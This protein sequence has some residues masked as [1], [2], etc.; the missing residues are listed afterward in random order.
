MATEPLVSAVIPTYN[1]SKLLPDAIESALNQSY[2]NIEIIVVDDGST[3]DTSKVCERYG[4]NIRYIRRAN[5][6]T[7]AARNSGLQLA[8]GDFV[9]LLDHDD[10]WLPT[11]IKSQVQ[12]MLQDEAIGLVH[13][14]GRVIDLE[15]GITTSEYVAVAETDYHQILSWCSVGCASAMIRRSVLDQLGGFDEDLHGVDDWDLWIRI[16]WEFRIVGIPDVQ[17]IIREHGG[18][19]G[20]RYRRMYPIVRRCIDKNRPKHDGCELC[21]LAIQSARRRLKQDY[22]VKAGLHSRQ[23]AKSGRMLDAFRAKLDSYKVHPLGLFYFLR[24]LRR[25]RTS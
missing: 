7:P 5:G 22:F 12:A 11:K 18:N 10:C 20:K 8:K 1:C 16:G 14:G 9:A 6:G 23:L 2:S 3:D 17:V 13:T 19:Q 4:N 25:Q 15:T 24:H 21:D